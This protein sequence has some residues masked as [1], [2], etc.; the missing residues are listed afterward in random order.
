MGVTEVKREDI[1]QGVAQNAVQIESALSRRKRKVEEIEN[2][3]DPD[4]CFGIVS[5]AE[6]W[7]FLKCTRDENNNPIF[8]LSSPYRVSYEEGRRQEDVTK[9][10]EII[11]WL[12]T[13]V[14][15]MMERKKSSER[16][17]IKL[18]SSRQS[19]C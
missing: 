19:S 12:L 17:R 9:V 1:K 10:V 15:D 8:S 13:E 16:K 18:G 2:D 7:L 14:E 6:T 5:D 11:N 4:P 3:E